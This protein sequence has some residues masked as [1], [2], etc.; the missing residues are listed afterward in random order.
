MYRQ[1]QWQE[2]L[3]FV[4]ALNI[5]ARSNEPSYLSWRGLL[6]ECYLETGKFQNAMIENVEPAPIHSRV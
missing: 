3:E 2:L 4:Q 1:Q 5:D 6:A